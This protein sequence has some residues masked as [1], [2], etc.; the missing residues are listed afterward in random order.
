MQGLDN[1]KTAINLMH[2]MIHYPKFT[3]VDLKQEKKIVLEEMAQGKDDVERQLMQAATTTILP[4]TNEYS[5]EVIGTQYDIKNI[6]LTDIKRYHQKYYSK[7]IAVVNA[8]ES[9][10]EDV[11]NMMTR[12][13]GKN[14]EISRVYEKIKSSFLNVKDNG[15]I[16][17]FHE[18]RIQRSTILTFPSFSIDR[19]Y[20][21]IIV[22]FIRF[23]LTNSG[24]NSLLF[25]RL[26]L[27]EQLVYSVTSYHEDGL[28]TGLYK[29]SFSSTYGDYI[30]VIKT[31]LDVLLDFRSNGLNPSQLNYYKKSY[32]NKMKYVFSDESMKE[33]WYCNNIFYQTNIDIETFLTFVKSIRNVDLLKV[34]QILFDMKK[35]GIVSSGKYEPIFDSLQN[36]T[37]LKSSFI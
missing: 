5:H 3:N 2:K 34:S 33:L 16:K 35:M 30:H 19:I 25:K 26:R 22:N 21:N 7:Y 31:V 29:I 11:K 23:V 12:L 36:F 20:D 13:F 14:I 9:I 27:D 28:G 6:T 17:L 15:T 8:D 1:Y 4:D 10:I 24:L 37:N 18:D 32:I